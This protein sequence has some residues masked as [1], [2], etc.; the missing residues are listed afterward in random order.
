MVPG[1]G[2]QEGR[3]GGLEVIG[4]V[5]FPPFSYRRPLGLLMVLKPG[6]V[7]AGS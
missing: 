1:E 5:R 6:M 4:Q 2:Q 3:Q 7:L